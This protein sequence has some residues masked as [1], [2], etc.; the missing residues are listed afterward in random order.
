MSGI[1][2]GM[3]ILKRTLICCILVTL[4]ACSGGAPNFPVVFASPTPIPPTAT[5]LPP[6]N[7]PI[8]MAITV[9]KDGI[10][11][12]ELNA[13]LGRYKAA[14]KASGN[15]VTE[16]QALKVV[17]D[18]FVD[19]LLLAAA[20]AEAG[21]SMDAAALQTRVDA[22]VAQIGGADKLTS[23]EQ[24]HGYSDES[25]RQALMRS[26]EAAWMRDK[27]MSSVPASAE[28][29]HV[30]Q[31]LLYNVDDAKNKYDR[32][33][34][35]AD[36]DELAAQ[37]DPVTRGD[38]G[39]FPRGY[40]ADKAVEDAAFSLEVGAYSAVV[41]S[42]VGFH[43]IKLLERQT[44]RELSPDALLALQKR[45]VVDWLAEQ[46]QKSSIILAP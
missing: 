42:E 35:G 4:A 45:A 16:Q 31:I 26:A 33:K 34:A 15:T 30:R 27:I 17:Q 7:T 32:L 1:I 20:A 21:F 28:Q 38:I 25:F 37:V 11:P 6:T 2:V 36:F 5:A 10:T 13:E 22:L 12:D 24:A 8:P 29:V 46:R 44:G 14:Q 23:W 41:P 19:Q 40:L 3:S 18:D 43:I 9:N 39:W